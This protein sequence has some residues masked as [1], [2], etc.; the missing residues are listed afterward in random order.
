MISFL[1]KVR[2]AHD[3]P[4]AAARLSAA[5]VYFFRKLDPEGSRQLVVMGIG[6]DRSTGDSLGPLVGSKLVERAPGLVVLGTL[7]NPV[8]ATN[9]SQCLRNL[10]SSL[11]DPLILAVDACLGR[12]ENVGYITLGEGPLRPGAGVHKELPS[13]GDLHITGVVN[14]GGYMEYMVLQNTRLSLV[15]RMAD[16]IASAVATTWKEMGWRGRTSAERLA[17]LAAAQEISC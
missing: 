1:P 7:D 4:S 13:V 2:V 17:S 6:T 16:T 15:M 9:L 14:V 8:H 10:R 3:D 12:P 11:S 5:L